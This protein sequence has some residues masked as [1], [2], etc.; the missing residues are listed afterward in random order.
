MYVKKKK[1][2]TKQGGYMRIKILLKEIRNKKG[3]S[4]EELSRATGISRSHLNY[5]ERGEKEPTL[6]IA[7]RIC[8]AL[9]IDIKEFYETIK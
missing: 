5:I 9:K 2:H 3:I 6:S 4:L 1:G 8:S 7:L